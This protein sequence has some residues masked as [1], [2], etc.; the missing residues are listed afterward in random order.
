MI[1]P[2]IPQ[3]PVS[4]FFNWQTAEGKIKTLNSE[5]STER[6]ETDRRRKIRKIDIDTDSLRRAGYLKPDETLV[7]VRVVD[8]N[9]RSEQPIFVNYLTQS[10]RLA[11]FDC[12]S[13]PGYTNEKLEIDFTKGMSYPGF[14][15]NHFKNIDGAQAHGWDSM[16]VI[17]DTSKP[18]HCGVEHIGHE[19]LMFPLDAKDLQA[20]EFIVRRFTFSI[21]K[22]E[23]FITKYGFSAEQVQIIKDKQSR[24]KIPTSIY[25]YKVFYKFN[26]CVY[27]AWCTL[28]QGCTDW[29]KPMSKLSLGRAK[30][31]TI[32]ETAVEQ[33]T[34]PDMETGMPVAV[35][36]QVPRVRQE[37]VPQEETNYPIRIY[38]YSESEEQCITDQKGRVFY[39]LPWQEAQIALRSLVMNGAVRASNVYGSPENPSGTGG[40]VK[41]LDITL[42]H[43]CFYSE[44]MKF[45]STAYPDPALLRMADSMDVRKKAEMGQLPAA[46]INRDDA[47]KTAAEITTAETEKQSLNSVQ[48]LLFSS[49]VREILSLAWYVVQS[50]AQQGLI[51]IAQIEFPIVTPMGEQ[52]VRI[53]D[54]EAINQVYDIKPAGDV[55]VVRRAEKL[56]QRLAG[57][58]I[59]QQIGG[60]LYIQYLK[61]LMRELLPE[62]ATKYERLLDAGEANKDQQIA[63]MGNMLR[64]ATTDESGAVKPEFKQHEAQLQ[65]I[66]PPE[67]QAQQQ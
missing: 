1:D 13:Q 33:R 43:G 4:D 47:R 66:L 56:Q 55:D 31:E 41:K 26:N 17:F 49:F 16:E 36:V 53:N 2:T 35:S 51:N 39:D 25:V 30:L 5:W 19:N 52:V 28:D 65:Q 46:V 24:E 9:I 15:K 12:I 7:G 40:P 27:V 59:V 8:E 37:W 64:A 57:L 60:P 20:C 58:P 38:L 3:I 32:R 29:L 21:L 50:Q 22:L 54:P 6:L 34:V 11:I 62:D 44:P 23:E 61:D 45:W 48:I 10:R 18:L 63:A 42:E 14:I 67:Q